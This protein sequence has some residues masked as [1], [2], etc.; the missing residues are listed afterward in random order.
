MDRETKGLDEMKLYDRFWSKVTKHGED[1][2]WIWNGAKSSSGHGS[3]WLNDRMVGAHLVTYEAKYGPVPEGMDLHHSVCETPACVNPDHVTPTPISRHR[4]IS[5]RR[6][7]CKNGHPLT[8]DNYYVR[9]HQCKI[10]ANERKK[11]RREEQKRQGK[12]VT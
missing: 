4:Y 2:C 7:H 11:L 12:R 6:L 10:C 8:G 3:F 1:G 9:T 5:K